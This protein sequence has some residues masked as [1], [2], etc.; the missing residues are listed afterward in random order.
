M[1]LSFTV[2]GAMLAETVDWERVGAGLVIYFL[3]LGI[4]AHAF[5]AVA[6]STVKPWGEVFSSRTLWLLGI[7]SLA[8]AYAIAIYYMVTAV[9]RLWPI[10]LAEGFLLLAYNLEWFEGRF[11][12]DAWFVLS[13]GVLPVLAGH[14]LQTNA[15]ALGAIVV[16]TAMGLVSYV[17]ISA[18]RP[19]KEIKRLAQPNADQLAA[20]ARYERILK[21]V[22]LGTILLAVG[23]ALYRAGF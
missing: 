14:V 10:A 23:L 20:G 8:A 16:G 5:D 15:L 19:Y 21:S 2:I 18:S 1:V 4:G 17:E 3:A 9:P 7:G 22:S 12:S 6:S 11:H 13:W